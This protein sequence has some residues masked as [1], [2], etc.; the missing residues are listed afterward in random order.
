M[1]VVLQKVSCT[2]L[3]GDQY[4]NAS[5]TGCVAARRGVWHLPEASIPFRE[6]DSIIVTQCSPG[7]Q[8]FQDETGKACSPPDCGRDYAHRRD[9]RPGGIDERSS[10]ILHRN[11]LAIFTVLAIWPFRPL[12][13]ARA[14]A[15]NG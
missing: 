2:R 8:D 1:A 9:Q 15:E 6:R 13:A 5:T 3:H 7:Q 10:K 11:A 12:R 14:K 4:L